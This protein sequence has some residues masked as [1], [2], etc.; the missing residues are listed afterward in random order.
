M[1]RVRV[2]PPAASL[3][4]GFAAIR[5]ELGL[6]ASFPDEVVE[7]AGLAAAEPGERADATGVPFVTIDP[8]GSRDLDQAY[9]AERRGSGY[10]VAYAIADP[11]AYVVPGGRLD[12]ESRARGATLY[13]PDARVPLYPP[14]LSEG[15][16]SLLAGETRPALV[17]RFDLDAAGDVT[18]VRV[19]RGVVRSRAQLDYPSVQAALD[20]GTADE[21]VELL[22][23]IGRLRQAVEVARGG[24]SLKT[25]AQE[26]VRL[27]DGG[28]ALAYVAPLPVENWNAQIS[29]MTGMAAARIM[30][31]GGVG[32]LRT[33]PRP[34]ARSVDALRRS[35]A[36]L[37]APWE[38][39]V[40]YPAFIRSLDPGVP[41]HAALLNLATTLL[42]GAGYTAFDGAPPEVGEH[43]AIAA[44]YAHVTAPLRRLAD[45]FA[46]EVVLALV[47][48]RE[49]PGWCRAALPELPGLMAAAD[50]RER[51]LDR[52]VLDY[53]EAAVLERRVGE[54][55]DAVVTDVDDRGGI[56][57][58][59]EPA[60]RARLVG[61]AP[62]GA[63]IEV[64]L[65]EADVAQRRV[66]FAPA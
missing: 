2:T 8:P 4:A 21:P 53:V 44:P 14:L 57:Q 61:T 1:A 18:D 28:Y 20:A 45:R 16:A 65:T 9:H 35:A 3:A 40:A 59:A 24:V 60:V 49:V 43:S 27:D 39:D 25:P 34:A 15:G 29:L 22:R 46:N 42:R 32:L 56:V 10:R 26:V 52:A 11:G 48:G 63:A 23:E 54:T 5:T 12:A 50:R 33:M 47:A 41:A 13:A 66:R 62:L 6:P 38:P 55:F 31:D 7:E 37:G 51:E 36:A 17:W 30:L 64:R 19:E 58:V